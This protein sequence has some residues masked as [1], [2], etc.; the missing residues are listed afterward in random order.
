MKK[1][2][3]LLSLALTLCLTGCNG[4]DM[5]KF[6][7]FE[8]PGSG[9]VD[10]EDDKEDNNNSGSNNNN[11]GS[12][13]N[14][15]GSN[16]NTNVGTKF[17][18]PIYDELLVDDPFYEEEWIDYD[19]KREDLLAYK[20]DDYFEFLNSYKYLLNKMG[21]SYEPSGSDFT[22]NLDRDSSQLS[23]IL[24]N[25]YI[26][27]EMSRGLFRERIVRDGEV[28]SDE[29]LVD[30]KNVLISYFNSERD[31]GYLQK[32]ERVEVTGATN[33]MKN[34]IAEK[35]YTRNIYTSGK[36]AT[37]DGYTTYNVNNELK[38]EEFNETFDYAINAKDATLM[39][40]FGI[41]FAKVLNIY[42]DLHNFYYNNIYHKVFKK[43]R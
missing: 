23:S 31:E 7:S 19:H 28:I 27:R 36:S 42:S 16:G 32:R 29:G 9:N 26:V 43:S 13:N 24:D 14:N 6:P 11:P 34:E 22:Y 38:E 30:Q 20:S 41:Y 21:V 40:I 15:P 3:L 37:Y 1:R 35:N 12:N 4:F 39:N 10:K 17:N 8:R 5:G 25:S 18:V 2:K 33:S